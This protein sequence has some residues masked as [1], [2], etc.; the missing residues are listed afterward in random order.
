MFTFRCIVIFFI[1]IPYSISGQVEICDNGIDDDND[2]LID[3]NDDDCK[4]Q[5]IATNSLIPNSS[6]EDLNCCPDNKSQLTCATDWIQASS[7]TTDFIH[8][9]GWSGVKE[10]P[11]P[12][13]FP[14]GEGIIGFRDGR[15]SSNDTL[16]AFWKEYAGACLISP[17]KADSFYRFQFDIGF[18]D[19]EISPP[20]NISLFGTSSCDYL[21]FGIGDVAFGC[22]SNSP[23]WI[24]LGEVSVSGGMGDTWVNTDID[25]VPEADIYAIAIG[26]DCAPVLS[27][28]VIYY[29]F[30]NLHLNELASFDLLMTESSHPCDQNFKLSVPENVDFEYQWYLSG[31]ALDGE[32]FPE[33]KQN[34]GEG[35]YQVR[36]LSGTSCRISTSYKY[37]IPSY[38]SSDTIAICKGD[39]YFF[40]D[41]E[42]TESGFYLDTFQT[43]QSCDS[44][45]SL[46]LEVIG[47]GY[48]TIEMTIAPGE[49]F[50]FGDNSYSDEGE[51]TIVIPSSLGC[52]SL[53]LLKLFHYNVFIPNVFSP[54]NDGVND[55]FHP[56][57]KE[58]EVTSYD[59]KIY[60]R[61]GNRIYQGG[62][63]DGSNLSPDVFVY[64]IE[65]EFIDGKTSLF[66]GSIT[67]LK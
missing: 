49:I 11:P 50:E 22:P 53:I 28:N 65:V 56:I 45:V 16:D 36:I 51:Y 67:L 8:L 34:Y 5:I 61:W 54:N 42:I 27:S 15:L 55:L 64:M 47:N 9:C 46:H 20:I 1:I 24:K 2:S 30:D 19:P 32:T 10:Y 7:P 18:V 31:V 52:D 14:D 4:C 21:P 41:L 12:R 48:D 59:M 3:I 17:M 37:T 6:F 66:Y 29:Y 44:I 26:P 43:Q 23:D 63:W 62:S 25:V 39:S 33:L 57:I 35:I 40:G 60:N 38:N 58:N 13:P